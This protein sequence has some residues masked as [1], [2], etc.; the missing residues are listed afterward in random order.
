M[1]ILQETFICIIRE[2]IYFYYVLDT[3]YKIT[4]ILNSLRHLYFSFNVRNNYRK[5]RFGNKNCY[6]YKTV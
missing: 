5:N 4:Q 6:Q 3:V 2:D 1:I